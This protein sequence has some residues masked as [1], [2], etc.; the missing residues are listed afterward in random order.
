[1][2]RPS[3]LK[4]RTC[5]CRASAH[6]T[7]TRQETSTHIFASLTHISTCVW[8]SR[9]SLVRDSSPAGGASNSPTLARPCSSASPR[10]P[11]W[12][13][14]VF[15]QAYNV[16]G[17]FYFFIYHPTRSLDVCLPNQQLCPMP[18]NMKTLA[19]LR[20]RPSLWSVIASV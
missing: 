6:N 9:A 8:F 16:L 1:M 18:R 7:E 2:L 17:P 3:L 14:L 20:H 19:P 5:Q 13:I 12:S 10:P 4:G 15:C 11:D